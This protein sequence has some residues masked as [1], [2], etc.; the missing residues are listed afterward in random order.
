MNQ[1]RRAPGGF[2]LIELLVV[3]AI[4]ALLIGILLPAL[5]KARK[6]GRM[7]V[8]MSNLKNITTAGAAYQ[9]DY[10]GYMPITPVYDNPN[11]H[12]QPRSGEAPQGLATWS[13][14]GKGNARYWL[15][16]DSGAFDI[17]H[18]SRPLNTYLYDLDMTRP[19]TGNGR[20]QS[21]A[22]ERTNVQ[23]PVFKDPADNVSLQRE[24]FPSAPPPTEQVFSCYDDVG[25]SYQMNVKWFYQ[26]ASSA[27][28]GVG[29]V[30]NFDQAFKLGTQRMKLAD[31]FTPS[32]FVWVH[33]QW[34][35]VVT[36]NPDVNVRI[37]NGYDD[38]N[39]SLMG[40]LDGHVAYNEVKPG[41]TDD[42]FQNDR[43]T[44]VY[45]DLPIPR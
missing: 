6:A 4:I 29:T 27:F 25:T 9:T 18:T 32:R 37:K 34:A 1:R 17:P 33:D 19:A 21:N 3:I 20:W 30:G 31:S 43:Y 24:P 40:Y 15:G 44:F 11:N 22:S 23:M 26:I 39:R 16:A 38:Y 36:H 12:T 10:K 42:A 8:S 14:G 41:V 35:D 13:F 5:G 28:G 2:T 7:A 45:D